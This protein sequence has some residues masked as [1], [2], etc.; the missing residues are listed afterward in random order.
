MYK[1]S[2]K[3]GK[4]IAIVD[5]LTEQSKLF[6][7]LTQKTILKYKKERKKILFVVNKKWYS[8]STICEDCGNVPRCENCW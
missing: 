7:D 1:L 8:S 5:L 3:E 4:K 6:W 2:E